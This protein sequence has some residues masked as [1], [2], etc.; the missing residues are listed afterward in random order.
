VDLYSTNE[1]LALLLLSLPLCFTSPEIL[2][3]PSLPVDDGKFYGMG[4]QCL[5]VEC[6]SI[7]KDNPQRKNN[8]DVLCFL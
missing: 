1:L 6:Y 5:K 2:L 4:R 7:S 8:G 3:H